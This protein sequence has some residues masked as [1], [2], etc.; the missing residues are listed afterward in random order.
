MVFSMA[1]CVKVKALGLGAKTASTP[2]TC[3]SRMIGATTMERAPRSFH[4]L[5]SHPGVCGCIVAA[6][7]NAFL[8]AKPDQ[9]SFRSHHGAC[10]GRAEAAAGTTDNLAGLLVKHADGSAVSVCECTRPAHHD[11]QFSILLAHSGKAGDALQV[12]L[13]SSQ[14]GVKRAALVFLLT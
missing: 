14:S 7:F 8:D 4:C 11:G 9:S 13:G 1:I 2:M 12:R 3:F 10:L 5:H 6:Q